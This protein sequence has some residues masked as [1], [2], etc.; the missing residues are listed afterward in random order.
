MENNEIYEDEMIQQE[1]S[2][3]CKYLTFTVD[4]EDYG[5]DI[6]CVKQI[7]G[8]QDITKLPNQSSFIMGVINLRGKV[9]PVIDI[10][11]RFG[12]AIQEYNER[13]CIIV[14]EVSEIDMGLIVDKVQEVLSI[15]EGQIEP[16]PQIRTD[17]HNQFIRGLGKISNS[18]KIILDTQKLLFDEELTQLAEAIEEK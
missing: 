10:R 5:L 3:D 16:P 15:P 18:V 9:I 1:E 8:M 12:L 11:L 6:T 7:L 14:I 17:I 13:T 4:N 2:N